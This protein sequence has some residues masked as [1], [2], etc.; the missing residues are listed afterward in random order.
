MRRLLTAAILLLALLGGIGVYLLSQGS[1]TPAS[2]AAT[3]RAP[4]GFFGIAPQTPLTEQ[5]ARYMKA[6]GI[7]AIRWPL[8]WPAIQPTKKGGY[9]WEAFDPTVEEAARQGLGVLPFVI[10]TP[11]WV[12]GK[13]TTLPIYNGAQRKAYTAF[14]KA[15][16]ERYGPGGEFWRIHSPAVI[17]EEQE[18]APRVPTTHFP[19]R[20]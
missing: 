15:A 5:D 12:A 1:T 2:A 20:S 7:E 19:A 14:L 9:N 17:R 11:H 10:A 8:I 3:P 6:G 16:V 18:K 4:K 13:E